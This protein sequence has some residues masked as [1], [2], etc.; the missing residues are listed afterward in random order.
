MAFV[1]LVGVRRASTWVVGVVGLVTTTQAVARARE[2]VKQP[3]CAVVG[4]PSS[5]I[6]TW[7]FYK[8]KLNY[9]INE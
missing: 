4:G 8:K 3:T 7:P 5:E 9:F 2:W 1:D 6:F